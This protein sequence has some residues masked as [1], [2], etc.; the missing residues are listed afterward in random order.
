MIKVIASL[1]EP[2]L[3]LRLACRL[4]TMYD[5]GRR[6]GCLVGAHLMSKC[7]RG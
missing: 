2:E 6:Q 4:R 1:L 7:R 5:V 3:T